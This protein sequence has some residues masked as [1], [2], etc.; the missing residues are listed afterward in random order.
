MYKIHP[1]LFALVEVSVINVMA[2]SQP[3]YRYVRAIYLP[4]DGQ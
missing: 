4:Q 2:N 1:Q 3:D